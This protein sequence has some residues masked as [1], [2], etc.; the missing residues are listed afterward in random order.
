MSSDESAE[1]KT[2]EPTPR[3]KR[4]AREQ[5][6]SAQS[7][8]VNN[9]AVLLAGTMAL[10][11]FGGRLARQITQEVTCRLSALGE[12]EITVDGVIPLFRQA[13]HVALAAVAPIMICVGGIGGLAAVLQS[14][15]TVAPQQIKPK[16]S[17]VNPVKG[18]KNIFSLSALMRLVVAL[19][20]I[21]LIGTVAYFL[22][23]SRLSWLSSLAG[24]HPRIALKAG[25]ELA[26]SLMTGVV[27]MMVVIAIVDYAYQR[28]K[29]HKELMMT[30]TERKEERK[31]EE[32]HEE[33][34]NR[35]SRMQREISQRRMMQA[36]PEADVVVSNPTHVAVALEW[37]EESMEA[38]I[39]VAKGT[40]LLAQRIKAIAR[41]SGVPVL[42]RA[43]LARTL[44]EAVEVD[45]E[46][47]PALYQAVAEVLAFVMKDRRK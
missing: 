30:K 31:R 11:L 34:Q 38:P 28:W 17:N 40:D 19:A 25:S 1:Q 4:R 36:V 39:V 45:M 5:G 46:I 23:R 29:H 10:T 33:V 6:Q 18:L 9:A 13:L 35:R 8:E 16:L 24:N 7:N 32:G 27:V 26:L 22:L 20:K 21:F 12:P 2:E 41:E 44:H 43:P 15:F 14:G 47:P 37:D 3:K 42:E